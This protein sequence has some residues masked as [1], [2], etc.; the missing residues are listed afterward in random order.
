MGSIEIARA[1]LGFRVQGFRE[2]AGCWPQGLV[3]GYG[4]D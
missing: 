2:G 3:H 4:F 1:G